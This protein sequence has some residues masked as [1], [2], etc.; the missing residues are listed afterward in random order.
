MDSVAG[1]WESM[2]GAS[3]DEFVHALAFPEGSDAIIEAP[4]EVDGEREAVE[5][6][7]EVLVRYAE[8]SLLHQWRSSF[9][10]VHAH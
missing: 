4:E 8:H 10:I 1:V 2:D 7:C 9:I 3:G 5:L 6:L